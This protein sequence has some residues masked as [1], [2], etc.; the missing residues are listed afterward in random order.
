MNSKIIEEKWQK[1]WEEHKSFKA[2]DESNKEPYYI[3]VEFP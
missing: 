3:L 1:Y 2:I